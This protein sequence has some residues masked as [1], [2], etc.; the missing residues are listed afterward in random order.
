[1]EDRKAVSRMTVG[2]LIVMFTIAL[3]NTI[4]GTLLTDFIDHYQLQAAMQGALGTFQSVGSVI[5][6]VIIA[7]TAGKIPKPVIMILLGVLA[8]ISMA[9][10]ALQPAFFVL[11]LFYV[12]FGVSKG[13][14]DNATSAM[15]ADL[16][17]GRRKAA[18]MGLLHGVFGIGGLLAPLLIV[19]LKALGMQ[20]NGVY[21]VFTGIAVLSLGAYLYIYAR[22]KPV[23]KVRFDH[24]QRI[25]F[26][27][28]KVFFQDQR[29]A[30]ILVSAFG[31]S[32]YQIGYYLWI[33]RRVILDFG[34]EPMGA[35]ALA[36]FWIGTAIARIG[37]PRFK[38]PAVK[39]IFWGNLAAVVFAL[40]GIWASSLP[41]V[42]VCS[43]FAGLANSS[44]ASLLLYVG[45]AWTRQNTMMVTTLYFLTVYAAQGACPP[46]VGVLAPT[47]GLP[48][49][50]TAAVLFALLSAAAMIPLRAE[51]I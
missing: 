46:L 17:D 34:N 16:H 13:L 28:L 49:G 27:G 30:F 7:I 29:N 43:F 12:V 15:I 24:D 37:A 11:I 22:T 50:M 38:V 44:A 6:L 39:L 2:I 31:F 35:A 10:S 42:L 32:V 41:V 18:N 3:C 20:W 5:A 23:L 9:G 40:G 51:K 26:S 8:V 19:Q 4:Q 48:W 1:M 45:C 33:S 25:D 47:A 14:S 36:L 21:I